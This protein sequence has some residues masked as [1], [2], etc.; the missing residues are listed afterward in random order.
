MAR[1]S[2]D[3]VILMVENDR[4]KVEAANMA[5]RANRLH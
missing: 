4:L 2:G 3:N 1:L 5:L